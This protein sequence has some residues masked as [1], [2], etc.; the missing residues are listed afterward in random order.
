[1]KITRSQLRR[2]IK[3]EKITLLKEQGDPIADQLL[4]KFIGDFERKL[5]DMYDPQ[6]AHRLGPEHVYEMT[7]QHLADE[8]EALVRK[9]LGDLWSGDIKLEIMG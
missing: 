5:L 4:G 2:I 8:V 9:R 6:G 1:M 3:E 7:V